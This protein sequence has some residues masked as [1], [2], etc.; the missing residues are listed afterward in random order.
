MKKGAILGIGALG[1]DAAA[2]LV[3]AENGE[4]LY[5]IA[6][7]RLRHLKHS[8]HFPYGCIQAASQY[9]ADH[10]F[11][12]TEAAINYRPEEFSTGT[13]RR[14]LFAIFQEEKTTEGLM[15]LLQ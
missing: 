13:L 5:A 3:S 12:I 10:G 2:A 9:A 14:E 6:E 15:A 11:E 7:E 8:W 1:H 4:V